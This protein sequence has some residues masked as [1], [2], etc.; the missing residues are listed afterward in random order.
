MDKDSQNK[1][2]LLWQQYQEISS[3]IDSIK[4]PY[5][6]GDV[7]VTLS[8]ED[9]SEHFGGEWE[10]IASGRTLVGVDGADSDFNVLGEAGGSKQHSHDVSSAFAQIF[11]GQNVAY[12]EVTD[13][14][15]YSY[16]RRTDGVSSQ[17]TTS[18]AA[19]ATPLIGNTKNSSSLQPYLAVYFWK[20]TA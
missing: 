12:T 2:D 14:P 5:R 1:L 3:R 4:S 7:L 15:S 6:V 18:G 19:A 16:T 20:R 17:D 11:I 8:D 9:P 13:H 10:K